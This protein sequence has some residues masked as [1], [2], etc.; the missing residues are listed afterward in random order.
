MAPFL[1]D[2]FNISSPVSLYKIEFTTNLHRARHSDPVLLF[3]KT[4]NTQNLSLRREFI[5]ERGK[6]YLDV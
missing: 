1:M 4:Y 2:R 5:K 3:E 6:E